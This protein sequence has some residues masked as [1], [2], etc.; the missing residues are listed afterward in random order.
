MN[1]I[2]QEPERM[3]VTRL[4]AIELFP[5]KLRETFSKMEPGI[6]EMTELELE[7]H[8]NRTPN[9]YALR[10]QLWRI[11]PEAH[12]SGTKLTFEDWCRGIVASAHIHQ[13]V[14]NSPFR[15]AWMFTPMET[16][17]DMYEEMFSILFNK[18]RK[19]VQTMQITD[20]NFASSIKLLENLANRVMGPLPRNIN[21]KAAHMH[22]NAPPK[23]PLTNEADIDRRLEELESMKDA[24]PV[25][26]VD[27]E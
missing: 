10:R 5:D 6:L 7:E 9:D 20:A 4:S 1:G 14:M 24:V 3:R 13:G 17:A 15:L 8:F 22:H 25:I 16:H 12:K 11:I 26:D 23:K 18:F 2:L 19:K 27:P 21:L